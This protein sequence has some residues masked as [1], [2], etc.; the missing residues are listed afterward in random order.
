MQNINKNNSSNKITLPKF[1]PSLF[2]GIDKKVSLEPSRILEEIGINAG[3]TVVDF[4]CGVGFFVIEAARMVGE[5]G[6]VIA[7]DIN[8]EVLDAVKK[9]SM[10]GGFK[11][12]YGLKADLELPNSTGLGNQSAD[13]VLIINLLYLVKERQNVI[14]EAY[15]ILRK[16]GR[17][18]VMDW[19]EK[20]KYR[21]IEEKQIISLKE[22]KKMAEEAGF[23]YQRTFNAGLSHEVSM[24]IK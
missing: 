20:G 19:R 16:G 22:I 3:E 9:K 1:D 2:Y 13:L 5:K 23:R 21:M 14:N 15:R 12:I 6:K 24:F 4:G 7:V 10:E 11:N 17:M 8:R 18:A